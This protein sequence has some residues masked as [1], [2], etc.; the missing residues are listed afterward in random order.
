MKLI[1]VGK[2]KDKAL[3]VLEKEYLKRLSP[4]TK[5]E[6][7]EVKD[8]SNDL[9]FRESESEK[10]K[11]IEGIRVLEKIRPT[12]FVVLLDLHGTMESS[13]TF[14]KKVDSWLATHSNIVFVIAGSLGPSKPLV[15]RAN[16]RWKLSDLTFTHLFTR[17]LVLEQLYRAYMINNNR[18]YHK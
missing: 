16:V 7:L 6:I 11:N 10:I 5:F 9:S 13:E 4:F 12:D 14:A 18:K 17:V 8:E 2:N 1:A 3:Q 15:Q